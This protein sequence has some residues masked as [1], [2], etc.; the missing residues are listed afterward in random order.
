MNTILH[1]CQTRFNANGA[2]LP[3]W[4][5]LP[6]RS[7][8]QESLQRG[9]E[10]GLPTQKLETWK[11]T[12]TRTLSRDNWGFPANGCVGIDLE[13]LDVFLVD[14]R[15][16]YRL[17]FVN[18]ALSRP[19][20]CLKDLPVGIR[21]ESMARMARESPAVL[22]PYL[23]NFLA[24]NDQGFAE[25]NHALWLDGAFVQLPPGSR[26]PKPLQL[27]FLTTAFQEP[28]VTLP[29][30]VV[31]AGNDAQATVIESYATLG[32]A[33]H[34]T[35]AYTTLILNP[36]ARLEHLLLLAESRLAHHVGTVQAIQMDRSQLDSKIF[37]IGGEL[38]RQELHITLAGEESACVQEGLFLADGRQHMDFHT[39]VHHTRSHTLS[40]QQ[41]KGVLDDQA[42]GVFNGVVRVPQGLHHIHAHQKTANL[43]LSDSTEIDAKP[44]LEI[45][46]DAVQCNHG[47]SVGT[48]DQEALFYLRSRGLDPDAARRVLVHG[49]ADELLQRVKP[50]AVRNWVG[51]CLHLGET[52]P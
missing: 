41:F 43:L 5:A 17:V 11:Y 36:Q 40:R 35:N 13:D 23:D 46:S 48:L 33:S 44:Q 16:A 1:T 28:I 22:T 52:S 9:L 3:G 51:Q 45:H 12:P 34:F 50:D 32:Q 10:S 31:V 37:S 42:H 20:S 26:L 7:S 27:L 6:I 47:A 25:I 29:W 15:E 4:N 49:F 21:V 19:L 39:W 30:N 2:Q 24:G 14:R 18:G 8:R 38:T